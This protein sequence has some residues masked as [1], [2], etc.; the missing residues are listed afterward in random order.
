MATMQTGKNTRVTYKAETTIGVA[1]TGTGGYEFR[2][3]A[4]GGLQLSRATINPNEV[5]ADGKTTMG[6]LGSKSVAGTLAADLSLG[7]FDTLMEA[8]VRGT[9]ST[10]TT[11][12]EATASL[13]SITTDANTISA[14]DGSWLTAGIRVGDVFR[15]TNFSTTANNNRNLR[16]SGVSTLTLTVVETLTTNAVADTS[17]TVTRAKKLI[18][19]TTPVRRSFTFD[20]YNIDID[21]S[22]QSSGCRI[23]SM[24]ITGQ[25]DGMAIVEFGIVGMDQTNIASGSSPTM[26]SATLTTSTPLTWV[27]A[28][29][30]VGSG[31]RTNLTAF[32][33]TYDLSAATL[34]VIGSSTS[35]DVFENN[36]KISGS[37]SY[38]LADFT[39]Y[40]AFIAE[41]EFEF[42]ALLVEP[43]S[44]PKDFISFFLPRLK[45]T[46]FNDPQGN[47]GAKI[48]T[49]PF[50]SGTKGT[51]TG[52]DDTMISISTSAA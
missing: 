37:L 13:T 15:L 10:A 41:T 3:N 27:D 14:T 12:T 22:K 39:D 38:A 7:T 17:F 46:G 21:L 45:Y 1:V 40:A 24:K 4:G 28:S 49:S 32:E 31:D 5:R 43:E 30:K 18:Q 8:V 35:P 11:I 19:P 2:K 9:W 48:A 44:E 52:Y 16:V 42:H 50:M 33:I 47:D 23:S 20:E 36:A 6:R 29:I 25:P 26:T 51:A 34:P